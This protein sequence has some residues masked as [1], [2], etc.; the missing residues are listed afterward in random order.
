MKLENL[1]ILLIII[2]ALAFILMLVL[3]AIERKKYKKATF[4]KICWELEYKEL[5]IKKT[6]IQCQKDIILHLL[7]S[8][9]K[10]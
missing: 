9:S 5:D 3:F 8:K 2:F 7:K 1:L 6:E 10:R 4:E